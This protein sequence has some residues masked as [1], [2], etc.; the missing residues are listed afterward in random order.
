[1]IYYH[2]TEKR[3]LKDILKNGLQGLFFDKKIYLSDTIELA[4]KWQ[5]ELMYAELPDFTGWIILALN[6]PKNK[7]KSG[8]WREGRLKE[9]TYKGNIRPEKIKVLK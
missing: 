2:N 9:F 4:K 5:D 3:D 8:Y 6:L 7:V 1:M